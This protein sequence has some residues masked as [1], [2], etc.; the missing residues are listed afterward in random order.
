MLLYSVCNVHR[1]ASCYSVASN[2]R[3]IG[4]LVYL[5]CHAQG[6]AHQQL[7]AI[8]KQMFALMVARL[9]GADAWLLGLHTLVAIVYLSRLLSLLTRL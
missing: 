5:T 2:K 9:R 6:A 4:T 1:Q 8:S 7:T 3:I